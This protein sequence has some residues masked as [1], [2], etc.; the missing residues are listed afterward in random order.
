MLRVCFGRSAREIVDNPSDFVDAI[1]PS[2]HLSQTRAN[3]LASMLGAIE[4][5][6]REALMDRDEGT[7]ARG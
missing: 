2:Q 5:R 1:G 6:A 4:R 7:G 3:G